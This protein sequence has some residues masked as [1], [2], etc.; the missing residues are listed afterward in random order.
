MI[1]N[2]IVRKNYSLSRTKIALS[3][4]TYIAFTITSNLIFYRKSVKLVKRMFNLQ[5]FWPINFA[6]FVPISFLN[7]TLIGICESNL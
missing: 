7:W 6:A 1:S 4:G 2:W 5:G 3:M